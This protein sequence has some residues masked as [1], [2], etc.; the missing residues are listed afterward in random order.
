MSHKK[1]KKASF[2]VFSAVLA[3]FLCGSAPAYA[4]LHS[5]TPFGSAFTPPNYP[6]IQNEDLWQ[7]FKEVAALG[8]HLS[9]MIHWRES[10][11]QVSELKR[12]FDLCRE[13]GLKTVLQLNPTSV[14][15]PAPP[16]GLPPSFG[17][18][19]VQARFLADVGSLA[20]L[21]P[22]YLVLATEVNFM[23]YVNPQEFARFVPLYQAAYQKVKEISPQTRIGAS[24]HLD[25][26]FAAEDQ[27]LVQQIGPQDFVG[28]TTY[29]AWT[30]YKGLYP[31]A[32]QIPSAYYDRIRDAV[33]DLPVVFSEVGW[34]SSGPGSD[35]DQADFVASLPRLMQNVRPELITWSMLHDVNFFNAGTL[36]PE[37]ADVI[38]SFNVTPEE[39]FDQLNS[40]G[41]LTREGPA[42]P[43][44]FQALE[45]S[46]AFSLF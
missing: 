4:Q 35:Q 19:E 43:A 23:H 28:F 42:K 34:P 25:L 36:T 10:N 40:M 29:P 6:D 1:C 16:S 32:G 33:P 22:D 45:L 26:F 24:F 27:D 3:A 31:Q 2:I 41:L 21:H 17:D 39:L 9:L 38:R 30:V 44:W 5:P 37:Q 46:F 8:N 15:Q 18:D 11:L 12:L 14:G 7:A 20:G 13:I